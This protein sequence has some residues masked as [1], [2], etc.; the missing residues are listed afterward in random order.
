MFPKGQ[1]GVG[2]VSERQAYLHNISS[3]SGVR[4]FPFQKTI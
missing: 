4:V 2:C 1:V 3:E